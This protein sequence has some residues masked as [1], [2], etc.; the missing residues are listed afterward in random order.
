MACYSWSLANIN[1][2]VIITR[3][4]TKQ[5]KR[6]I[7]RLVSSKLHITTADQNSGNYTFY[8]REELQIL[9]TPLSSRLYASHFPFTMCNLAMS[10][11]NRVMKDTHR[12]MRELAELSMGTGDLLLRFL[13]TCS[14]RLPPLQTIPT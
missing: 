3:R 12:F 7:L 9:L 6:A 1:A 8:D 2:C 14:S 4:R 10:T 13:S 5:Y 11:G